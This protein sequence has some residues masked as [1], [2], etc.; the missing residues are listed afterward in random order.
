MDQ[1]MVTGPGSEGGGPL[2][3]SRWTGRRP[4]P[5]R[6]RYLSRVLE[7]PGRRHGTRLAGGRSTPTGLPEKRGSTR[8]SASELC[9]AKQAQV[10]TSRLTTVPERQETHPWR[11]RCSPSNTL[12][13][14]RRRFRNS[15]RRCSGP[16]TVRGR[17][18][19]CDDRLPKPPQGEQGDQTRCYVTS[20]SARNAPSVTF[21]TCRRRSCHRHAASTTSPIVW[22]S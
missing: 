6:T 9:G 8:A 5:G 2:R 10:R 20:P 12:I 4:W 22:R 14:G 1:P 13:I 7:E 21:E 16:R 17:G 18:R 19:R 11:T 15:P 3:P